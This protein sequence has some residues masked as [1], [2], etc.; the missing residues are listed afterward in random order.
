MRTVSAEIVDLNGELEEIEQQREDRYTLLKHRM[1]AVYEK[2]GK[3]GMLIHILQS[4]TLEQMLSRTEYLNAIIAYDQNKIEE[5]R[6]RE[7]ELKLKIAE[8]E[9][10][11]AQL[12][13]YQSELDE[14]YDEIEDLTGEVRGR[15]DSTNSSLLSENAKLKNYAAQLAELDKKMKSLASQAAAAQA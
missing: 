12:D 11:E 7:T 4:G 6:Q 9:E 10:K 2:G 15:L 8:V 14:K 5:C 3:K 1:K 13:A